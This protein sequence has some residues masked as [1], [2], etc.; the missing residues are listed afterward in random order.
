MT[1][2]YIRRTS[3]S[4]RALVLAG[5]LAAGPAGGE[6][7]PAGVRD[8]ARRLAEDVGAKAQ[9]LELLSGRAN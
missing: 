6:A 1:N 4:F 8:I 7:Y 2:G 9:T 3:G 5:C